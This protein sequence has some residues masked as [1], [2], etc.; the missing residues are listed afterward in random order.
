MTHHIRLEVQNNVF[1]QKDINLWE[2]KTYAVV[3]LQQ[4]AFSLCTNFS[5]V[6]KLNSVLKTKKLEVC[7]VLV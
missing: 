4:G 6:V 2:K 3:K 7:F 1:E 5:L